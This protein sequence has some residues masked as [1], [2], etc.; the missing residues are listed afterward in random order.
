M[1][2]RIS[3]YTPT[4]KNCGKEAIVGRFA[5]LLSENAKQLHVNYK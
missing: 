4:S 2:I 5:E 3:V 1:N